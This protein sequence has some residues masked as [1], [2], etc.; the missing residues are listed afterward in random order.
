VIK[1]S[2]TKLAKRKL[3]LIASTIATKSYTPLPVMFC[4]ISYLW[5][6]ISFNCPDNFS[7]CK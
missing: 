4:W 3:L 5:G 2:A 7:V 6:A 1:H